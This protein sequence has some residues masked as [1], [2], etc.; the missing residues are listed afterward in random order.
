M[1]EIIEKI[2]ELKKVVDNSVD[3]NVDSDKLKEE[4]D[5]ELVDIADEDV[6]LNSAHH[7]N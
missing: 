1:D 5:I 4:E 3:S 6:Y 7:R 2:E